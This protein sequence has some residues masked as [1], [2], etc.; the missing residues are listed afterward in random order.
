MPIRIDEVAATVPAEQQAQGG[1]VQAQ[2]EAAPG[3]AAQ[4]DEMRRRL[5]KLEQRRARVR[6][7]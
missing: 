1:E 6:A 7:D 5:R 4:M 3:P 2:G